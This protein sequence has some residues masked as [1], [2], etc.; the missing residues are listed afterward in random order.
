VQQ[1]WS[2]VRLDRMISEL[3]DRA[4]EVTSEQVA[5]LAAAVE[6]EHRKTTEGR[7]MSACCFAPPP[8]PTREP[9][10][11]FAPLNFRRLLRVTKEYWRFGEGSPTL[12]NVGPPTN[13]I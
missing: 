3:H 9:S 1:R 8:L 13:A 5:E 11:F 2:A 12:R 10:S 4:D 6:Q 7:T